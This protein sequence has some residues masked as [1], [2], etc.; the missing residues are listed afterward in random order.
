MSWGRGGGSGTGD[1]QVSRHVSKQIAIVQK[2]YSR[3]GRG[4]IYT[5]SESSLS[6]LS[7]K[8]KMV[9]TGIPSKNFSEPF[10]K[11]LSRWSSLHLKCISLYVF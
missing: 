4:Q 8:L 6:A 3:G 5:F 10:R 9:S 11:N 7:K 1:S 2:L